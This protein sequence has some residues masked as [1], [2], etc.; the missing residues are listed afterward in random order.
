MWSTVPRAIS[1]NPNNLAQDYS[2]E[3]NTDYVS[4]CNL[5]NRLGRQKMRNVHQVEAINQTKTKAFIVV[6]RLN[7]IIIHYINADDKI[8]KQ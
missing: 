3:W 5:I 4:V 1:E 2:P 6:I 8:N 7:W